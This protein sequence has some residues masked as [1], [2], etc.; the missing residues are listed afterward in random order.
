[1]KQKIKHTQSPK[2]NVMQV[3][4]EKKGYSERKKNQNY[5]S[6]F[7]PSDVYSS[8]EVKMNAFQNKPEEARSS[9]SEGF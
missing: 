1:V 5:D 6:D 7:P 4:E 3:N 2:R 9:G 8:A